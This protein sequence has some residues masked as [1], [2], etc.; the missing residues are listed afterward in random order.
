M[1]TLNKGER[2]ELVFINEPQLD[3]HI[4]QQEGSSLRVI[5]IN[6]QFSIL[7]SI[8]VHHV[9]T[10]CHTEI[11]ALAYLKNKESVRTHTHVHHDVGGGTSKQ[12][13]KFVLD[14]EAQGEFLGEL[15]IL[16]NA[17]QVQ[18]EQTNRNLLLSEKATMRTRPQLEIYADDVKASHGATTGQLDESA[19]FYMQQRGIDAP[20]ARRM[21]I[22]A[23]MQDIAEQIS[24]EGKRNQLL[25]TID[26]VVE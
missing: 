9:G 3:L 4:Q 14:D 6:S 19:L 17:Q 7:N 16:P 12:V 1:L 21:L 10:G 2:Q 8:E 11:Y 26:G 18:A 15:K 25:Q 5:V 20:T 23:F 24:D 22:Q 13:I